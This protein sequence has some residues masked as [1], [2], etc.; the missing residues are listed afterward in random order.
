[1]ARRPAATDV[2]RPDLAATA[3]PRRRAGTAESRGPEREGPAGREEWERAE[4][5]AGRPCSAPRPGHGYCSM[6]TLYVHTL[7]VH[8]YR[9][10]LLSRFQ[11][12][13]CP[14]WQNRDKMSLTLKFF[15]HPA[16]FD[17]KTYCLAHGFLPNSSK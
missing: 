4:V 10:G 14:R 15:L 16:G 12:G 7:A 17:F 3:V 2:P 1:M 6:L 9:F 8:Y 13:F 5:L 11:T